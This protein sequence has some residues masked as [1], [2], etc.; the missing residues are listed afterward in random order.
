MNES[1]RH[2][3]LLDLH[4]RNDLIAA[5]IAARLL[6]DKADRHINGS[7]F[8]IGKALKSAGNEKPRNLVHGSLLDRS[9]IAS[10]SRNILSHG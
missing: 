9:L 4:A 8:G 5:G 6:T 3:N 10:A 2:N 7:L 1:A